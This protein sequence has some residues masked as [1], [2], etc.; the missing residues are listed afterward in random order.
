M[1]PIRDDNPTID[2]SV[3]TFGIIG[4]NVFT[5]IFIQGLGFEPALTKSVCQFG[6]ISGEVLGTVAEGTRIPVSRNFECI[7][8]HQGSWITV[9]THM[10]MH[11]GWFHLIGNM[12]FLAV[13]GDNVEDAMGRFRFVIFYI[14]C[15]LAA[16]G[17]QMLADPSSAIPMVGASGA[18][19]GIMGAY[20]LLY[21]K[22]PVHMLIFFGFFIDRVIIPAYLMLGYWFIIQLVSASLPNLGGGGGVAFW[23]HIGGFVAGAVLIHL[24]KDKK[25][26]EYQRYRF[27]R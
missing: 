15:G 27:Y 12:W 13:F 22:S 8:A 16:F 11:G 4:I 7:I 5:W 20:A 1:F 17:A 19:G 2:R 3:I 25:R 23:A 26:V 24:F 10:F 21:P 6:A 9:F 18:I 14:V